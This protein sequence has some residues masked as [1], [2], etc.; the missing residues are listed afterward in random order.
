MPWSF[1][2]QPGREATIGGTVRA[3]QEMTV[4]WAMVVIVAS[5]GSEL[6]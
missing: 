5:Y 6:E 3:L 4:Q 2:A 1:P